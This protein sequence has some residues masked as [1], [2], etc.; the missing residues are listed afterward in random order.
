LCE[1]TFEVALDVVVER[2]EWRDVEQVHRIGQRCVEPFGD[3]GVH[4]P[5][6]GRQRL[7]C[8]R[9]SEDE[10]VRA[11]GDRRPARTLRSRWR[12]ER[13]D[14]PLPD[15]G[16]EIGENVFGHECSG[17]CEKHATERGDPLT[18]VTDRVDREATG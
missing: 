15:N 1:R 7:S 2:L 18:V 5:E 12:T 17:S 3:E 11:A 9:G 16:M 10:R 8:A 13:I 6:E 4:L 14:E